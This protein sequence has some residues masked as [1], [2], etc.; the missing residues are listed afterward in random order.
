MWFKKASV[1]TEHKI[2]GNILFLR[3]FVKELYQFGNPALKL[4]SFA[5]HLA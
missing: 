5:Q 2:T 4:N 1:F 3:Y